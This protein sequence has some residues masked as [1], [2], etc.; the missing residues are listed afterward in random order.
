MG[1]MAWLYGR[2][3]KFR[4]LHLNVDG[5]GWRP[6]T[7]FPQYSVRDYEIKSGSKGWATYQ[8]LRHAGWELI[9]TAIAES[10]RLPV[11]AMIGGDG[12][13]MGG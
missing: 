9:E 5:S 12:H 3:P 11:L 7:H 1:K 4:I 8:K 2:S 13:R 10:T 6:Y